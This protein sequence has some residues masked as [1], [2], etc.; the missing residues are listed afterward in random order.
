MFLFCFFILSC[1]GATYVTDIISLVIVIVSDM[2]GRRRFQISGS[3]G[4]RRKI[5]SIQFGARIWN[6]LWKSTVSS[7]SGPKVT[8]CLPKNICEHLHVS[9]RICCKCCSPWNCH[10]IKILGFTFKLTYFYLFTSRFRWLSKC[11]R[12]STLYIC[13]SYESRK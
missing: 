12:R 6:V 2:G 8:I 5:P 10:V 11:Q 13:V 3:E 7:N 4:R 9:K 1:H